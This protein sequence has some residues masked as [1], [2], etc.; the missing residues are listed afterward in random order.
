MDLSD[1]QYE[2]K[3]RWD[4]D[5][6]LTCLSGRVAKTCRIVKKEWFEDH[7]D[8]PAVTRKEKRRREAWSSGNLHK[9]HRRSFGM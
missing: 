9:R 7:D 1:G 3:K 2:G 4:F 6:G 8:C 5:T